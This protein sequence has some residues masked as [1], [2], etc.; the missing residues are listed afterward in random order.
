MTGRLCGVFTGRNGNQPLARLNGGVTQVCR[1][2]SITFRT[3]QTSVINSNGMIVLNGRLSRLDN[4]HL[5][6]LAFENNNVASWYGGGVVDHNL[7][8]YRSPNNHGESVFFAIPG[9]ESWGDVPWTQSAQFGSG[10][11]CFM[12]DNAVVNTS[13]FEFSVRL[14]DGRVADGSSGITT[15]TTSEPEATGPRLDDTGVN[16]RVNF[17][18]TI[19]TGR[20]GLT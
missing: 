4:C 8:E 9:N 7:F 14:T 12:E 11:F 16:G 6:D 13:G 19:F 10:N 15:S 1:L 20:S 5:D 17:T 2:S 18:T 3:G